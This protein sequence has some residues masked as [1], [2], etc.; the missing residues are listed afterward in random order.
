LFSQPNP[1]EGEA[2][3]LDLINPASLII[4]VDCKAEISLV[5]AVPGTTYQFE[6]EGY[7]C[8]DPRYSTP[9]RLVFNRTISLRDSSTK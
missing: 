1:D 9:E 2:S 3:F 8:V 5:G 4:A 6:R 7:F